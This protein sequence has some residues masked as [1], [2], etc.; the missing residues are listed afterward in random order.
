MDNCGNLCR[1]F[2]AD[3]APALHACSACTGDYEDPDRTAPPD[4][5]EDEDDAAGALPEG[6]GE[7]GEENFCGDR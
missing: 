5:G 4:E 3:G 6:A 1:D 2:D 7:D